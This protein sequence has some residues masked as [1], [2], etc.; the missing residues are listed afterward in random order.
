MSV[1][2]IIILISILA[3]AFFSAMELAFISSN[4]LRIEVMKKNRSLKSRIIGLFFH[5]ESTMIASLLM[6]NNI[7][8]VM[9][10]IAAARVLNPFF[11]NLG[12]TDEIILL[13]LQTIT[14][15]IIVLVT[16]EFLPKALVQLNPNRFLDITLAP[17]LILYILLYVPTQ[18]ILFFSYIILK[19]FGSSQEQ[20]ARVFSKVDLEHYVEELSSR[21]KDEEEFS[22]EMLIL[23]NALDFSN[24]KARDCMIPRTEIIGV[25]IEESIDEAKKLLIDK[26]LSKLIVY[27]DDIDNIIGYIH[28]FDLFSQP[29]S[30]KQI[31]KPISFVPTVIS[32]KELLEKFT[33]Q[34]GN[35]AVVTD[36]YGGTAGIITLEDVIEEIFGEIEDEHD[37][38]I[39]L[40]EKINE[41]EFLFYA[42]IDIDYLNE[43]FKLSLEE[44]EEYDTL[45]GLIIHHIESIP[46]QGDSVQLEKYRLVVEKV[47][48]RK[49]ETVRLFIES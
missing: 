11:V 39:W 40:E 25:E 33:K 23:R 46:T 2:F 30:I 4:R 10:G 22:N 29:K 12:V 19:L 27:R 13:I 8:L 5:R 35:F 37:K 17:M 48:D 28:S 9:Y 7:A 42:R 43:T 32:G 41:S 45:A 34:A 38:E 6:G 31:L 26:G 14:S 44:S 47:S 49:I 18:I 24:I 1:D 15:T 21:I 20:S 16:A 3:S 36:E